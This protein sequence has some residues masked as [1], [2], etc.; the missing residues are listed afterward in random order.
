MSAPSSRRRPDL[1]S[2]WFVPWRKR[3]VASCTVASSDLV[4]VLAEDQ[5]ALTVRAAV[6]AILFDREAQAVLRAYV[7]LGLGD[8]ALPDLLACRFER[9]RKRPAP[10]TDNLTVVRAHG[11]SEASR[12][13]TSGARP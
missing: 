11:P 7:D 1:G 8:V 4:K 13:A 5:P 3:A 9:P 6:D 10:A 12:A 2:H